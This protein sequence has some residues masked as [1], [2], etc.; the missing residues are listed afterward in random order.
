MLDLTS[1]PFRALLSHLDRDFP[2]AE[3]KSNSHPLGLLLK[4]SPVT[5]Q[6]WR[7]NALQHSFLFA[8]HEGLI[9]RS[10]KREPKDKEE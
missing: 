10:A 9:A 1:L 7:L 5:F 2:L 3:N 4:F 6:L 8:V